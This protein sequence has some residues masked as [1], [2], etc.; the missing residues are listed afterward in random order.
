MLELRQARINRARVYIRPRR[1]GVLSWERSWHCGRKRKE[2]VV[3]RCL[4]CVSRVIVG[5]HFI[6]LTRLLGSG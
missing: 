3:L 4:S 6:K 5:K 2:G 1:R